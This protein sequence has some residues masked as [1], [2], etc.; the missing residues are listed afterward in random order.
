[1]N[2]EPQ[3]RRRGRIK[4]IALAAALLLLYVASPYYAIW[5]FGDALRAHDMDALAARVDFD[6]VRGSLKQQIRDHFLGV[7]AK[8]KK[9]NRLAEFLVSSENSPLDQLVDAY[10]TPEGLAAII[11]DPNPIRNASSLS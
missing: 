1:M 6:A 11:S 9:K 7:V 8:N 10:V 5:R 2:P 3:P 4:W